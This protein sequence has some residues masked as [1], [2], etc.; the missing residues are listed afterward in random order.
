MAAVEMSVLKAETRATGS[1]T[2]GNLRK[3]GLMPVVI[4]GH[5]QEPVSIA[6]NQKAFMTG[7][8]QGL[9]LFDVEMNGKA[10]KFLLKDVQYDH[11]GI[12]VLH[13]DLMRVDLSEKVQVAV[14]LEFKGT[15]KGMADGG[16]VD[17]HMAQI[18]VEC[19]V[20]NIPDSIVVSIKELGVGESIHAKDI[21]LAEGV[22]LVTDGEAL[23]VSCHV[24][25]E[26]AAPA[27][28]EEAP[29]GPEVIGRKE[30]EEEAEAE[31]KA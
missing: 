29:T 19:V 31:E 1:K 30:K 16:I 21:K 6:V 7:L 28:A 2:A 27:A 8:K 12:S 18:E 14:A 15:A 24:V 17:Q 10:D 4:Y 22:K 9:R 25:A 3:Q 11:L 26:E 20:T 13:A 5:K 23:V